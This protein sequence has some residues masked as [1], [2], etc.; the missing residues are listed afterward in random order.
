[1]R[2]GVDISR[3]I[4]KLSK[5]AVELPTNPE[6]DNAVKQASQPVVEA[7]KDMYIKNGNVKTRSLI[8]SVQSFKRSKNGSDGWFTYYV[9]VRYSGGRKI[10]F[11]GESFGNHAHF[12]E[13]G[14]KERQRS[15]TSKGGVFA[16]GR[17]FGAKAN[18]GMVKA[19]NVFKTTYEQQKE[20][21]KKLIIKNVYQIIKKGIGKDS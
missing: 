14:T 15:V 12:L 21:I 6:L 9:G 8:N 10:K 2:S 13:K 7:V 18:T 4:E 16:A 11:A 3:A 5:L 19:N 17:V 1:M 20:P